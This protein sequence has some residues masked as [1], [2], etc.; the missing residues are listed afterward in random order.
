MKA[1]IKQGAVAALLAVAMAGAQA[2]VVSAEDAFTGASVTGFSGGAQAGSSFDG[3]LEDPSGVTFFDTGSAGS[4]G[5]LD[6]ETATAVSLSGIHLFAASDGAGIGH[7]R[8]M[9][10]FRFYSDTDNDGVYETLLVN[11]GV[12]PDYGGAQSFDDLAS[13]EGAL[14]AVFMFG[15]TVTASRFRYEVEQGVTYGPYAGVR[16]QEIDAI[17]AEVPEP[18]SLALLGLGLGALGLRRRKQAA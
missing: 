9:S 8:S 11:V 6:F 13:A 17:T 16:L 3:S 7:R 18:A 4:L 1:L 2:G 15:R 12:N 14:E 10:A 5:Y